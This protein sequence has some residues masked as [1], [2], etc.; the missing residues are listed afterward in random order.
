MSSDMVTC[1]NDFQEPLKYFFTA[2]LISYYITVITSLALIAIS[3]DSFNLGGVSQGVGK[4]KRA[5]R[6]FQVMHV[7]RG[8]LPAIAVTTLPCVTVKL[9]HQLTDLSST[10]GKY[11]S[12]AATLSGWVGSSVALCAAPFMAQTVFFSKVCWYKR[13]GIAWKAGSAMAFFTALGMSQAMGTMQK[14][15]ASRD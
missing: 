9:S 12:N 4:W 7:R 8:I 13:L 2:S 15:K 14:R 1:K 6:L 11:S 10:G 5:G 3:G